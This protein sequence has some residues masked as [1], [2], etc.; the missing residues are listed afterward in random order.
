MNEQLYNM[1]KYNLDKLT[2][3]WEKTVL[4]FSY[5][6]QLY[7]HFTITRIHFAICKVQSDNSNPG[8]VNIC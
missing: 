5:H 2:F 6:L 4:Q 8:N 7:N 3:P 1:E